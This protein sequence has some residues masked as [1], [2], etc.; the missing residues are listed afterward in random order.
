ME[1]RSYRRVFELERRVY[2][3]DR[4]RLNPGGI[5]VRGIVYFGLAL[6]FALVGAEVPV[7]QTVA[8]SVPWFLWD[9]AFPVATAA[10][11]AG[12]RVEGRAFHLFAGGI[13]RYWL[14][15]RRLGGMR[16]CPARAAIW[17]PE[18]IVFL[19]NG[20]EPTIRRMRITGPAAVRVARRH[21]KRMP[22]RRWRPVLGM[23]PVLQLTEVA[24]GTLPWRREVVSLA[25]GV[26]MH[27]RGRRV[28]AGEER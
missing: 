17:R 7:A 25:A 8:R 9:L 26:H 10:V 12:V 21:T 4:L 14:A 6:G 24:D 5:P 28:T 27:T 20:S 11:L 1:V 23:R 19:P 18:E 2:R 15:P 3:V 22:G 16:R 13:A